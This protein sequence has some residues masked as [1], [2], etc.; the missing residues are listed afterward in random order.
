MV[1]EYFQRITNIRA[2]NGYGDTFFDPNCLVVT[3]LNA[4]CKAVLLPN[5][6][7]GSVWAM[8]E[9]NTG[10]LQMQNTHAERVGA[11]SNPLAV[12]TLKAETDTDWL[13]KFNTAAK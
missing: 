9:R 1:R 6:R 4:N 12:V 8:Y 5:D 3:L 7:W 13:T 10:A 11:N 2:V